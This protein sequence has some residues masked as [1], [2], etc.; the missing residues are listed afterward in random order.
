MSNHF[1]L[2]NLEYKEGK[3]SGFAGAPLLEL[4]K[5]SVKMVRV[6]PGAIYHEHLHHQKTEYA[7][8]VEGKPEFEIDGISHACNAGDFCIFPTKTMHRIL[9]NDTDECLLLIGSI[10]N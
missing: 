2:K 4:D 10:N 6:K 3:V 9:N 7:F 5:G 8:V 1:T